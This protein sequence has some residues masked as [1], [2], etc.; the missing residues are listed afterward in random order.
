M[1]LKYTNVELTSA[2]GIVP[3]I[4]NLYLYVYPSHSYVP[5]LISWYV[6]VSL[7]MVFVRSGDWLP[8]PTNPDT[9]TNAKTNAINFFIQSHAFIKFKF[10]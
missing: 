10:S 9:Q 3:L 4:S 8:Q 2:L 6:F 1:L 5:S 7:S